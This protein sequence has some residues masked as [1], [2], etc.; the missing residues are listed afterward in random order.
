M[1]N[2][3]ATKQAQLTPFRIDVPQSELDDLAARLAAIRWPNEVAEAGTD[4]GMPVGTVQ[5]LAEHWRT[6]YD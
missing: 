2:Q 5:R 6:R 4:Y 3:A 1:T